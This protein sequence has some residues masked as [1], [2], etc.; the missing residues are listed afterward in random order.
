[1]ETTLTYRIAPTML[2]SGGVYGNMF[3]LWADPTDF[4]RSL[5]DHF[6]DIVPIGGR[7]PKYVFAFGPARNQEIFTNTT[8]FQNYSF[9]DIPYFA[10]SKAYA[11]ELTLGLGFLNGTE[12]RER[13]RLLRPS[14]SR[15]SVNK[16][17]DVFVSM[18]ENM[19]ASWKDRDTIEVFPELENLIVD[20]GLHTLMG[21][22]PSPTA[23]RVKKLFDEVFTLVFSI[24]YGFLPVNIPGTA[25]YRAGVATQKLSVEITKLIEQKQQAGAQGDDILSQLVRLQAENPDFTMENLIG[26]AAGIFRGMYPNVAS[27]LVCAFLLLALHPG[28]MEDVLQEIHDQLHGRTP[29]AEDLDC[30]VLLDAV[31]METLR[32]LPP[33]YWIARISRAPFVLGGQEF[34]LGSTVLLSPFVTQRMAD[35]YPEP[36]RFLPR[37]WIGVRHQPYA[38]IP[39]A[40]GVR[41]CL[42]QFYTINLCKAVMTTIL[43]RY[44]L[45]LIPHTKLDFVGTRRPAPR[46]GTFMKIGPPGVPVVPEGLGGNYRR[47]V[48]LND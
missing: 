40:V 34:P 15:E 43:Q 46:P 33:A 7:H 48:N 28:I 26:S 32:I 36:D 35:V 23:E 25:Y 29:T 37:R 16:F 17:T 12:H 30:L 10:H 18:T 1:M 11:R 45:S 13:R 27:A 19:L 44:S 47:F 14:F 3:M 2:R 24:S 39:F 38:F 31:I 42:G 22:E 8:V 5:Y 20:M 21:L 4:M 6:G 41:Q 9:D